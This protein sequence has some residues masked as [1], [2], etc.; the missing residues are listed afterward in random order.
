MSNADAIPGASTASVT[1]CFHCGLPVPPGSA[2]RFESAEGWR[3]FCCAGCEAVCTA[4]SG[5]GLDHYYRLRREAPA[6]PEPV[7]ADLASFDAPSIRDRFVSECGGGLVEAELLVEGMR[8]AACAWLV[9]RTLERAPGVRDVQVQ[10]A[11]RRARVQWDPKE[12]PPSAL[13]AAVARIG[14][15]AWPYDEDGDL[16]TGPAA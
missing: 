9:E 14:Y 2:F 1:G 6:R 5:L 16:V 15:H 4:I 7:P 10:Y 13:L 3:S 12:A 8:C 11:T